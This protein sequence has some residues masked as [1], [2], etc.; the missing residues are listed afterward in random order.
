M[1]EKN[2]ASKLELFNQQREMQ[3]I[4]SQQRDYLHNQNSHQREYPHNQNSHQR[5][6]PR[7]H[8]NQ[9][10]NNVPRGDKMLR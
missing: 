8:N 10:G 7:N 6:H 4:N 9:Q 2:A 3:L 5:E 1:E